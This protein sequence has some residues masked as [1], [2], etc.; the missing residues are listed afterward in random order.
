MLASRTGLHEASLLNL[1][2]IIAKGHSLCAIR[3]AP[4]INKAP[5]GISDMVEE[6][7]DSAGHL[8]ASFTMLNKVQTLQQII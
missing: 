3:W 7:A 8:G 1:R 2:Q 4:S 6:A 5:R